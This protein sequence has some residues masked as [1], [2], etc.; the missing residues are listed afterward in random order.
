MNVPFASLVIQLLQPISFNFRSKL[1][2]RIYLGGT[3][4]LPLRLVVAEFWDI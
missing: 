4:M 3:L 1:C 2:S